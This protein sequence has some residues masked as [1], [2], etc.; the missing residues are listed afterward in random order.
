MNRR[1]PGRK[2]PECLRLHLILDTPPSQRPALPAIGVDDHDRP[3]FLR[4][5]PAGLDH[6]ANDRL[7]PTLQD[8]DQMPDHVTHRS[9]FPALLSHARARIP[10]LPAYRL[11]KRTTIFYI[12]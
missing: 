9:A 12:D 11:R 10:L 2:L 4:R 8:L 5:R 7:S 3:R 6:L 1:G